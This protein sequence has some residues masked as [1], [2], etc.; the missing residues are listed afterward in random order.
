MKKAMLVVGVLI[1]LFLFV[2][3]QAQNA[4]G[5]TVY[6]DGAALQFD[7]NPV[8]ENGRTLVPFRAIFEALGCGVR[9][10][11]TEGR[12]TVSAHRGEDNLMLTIGENKMYF[13]E[14]EIAL[15]APAKIVDNRTLVPL[16]AVSEAFSTAVLWEE[17]TKTVSLF[18][19]QGEHKI[20]PAIINKEIKNADGVVIMNI[21]CSYPVIANNEGSAFIDKINAEYKTEAE[22]FVAAA[23][24]SKADAE[25]Y[26]ALRDLSEA[27]PYE[28]MQTFAVNTDKNGYLSITN[29][30]YTYYGGAHGLMVQRSRTFDL[31]NNKELALTDILSGDVNEKVYSVFSE[32]FEWA[33]GPGFDENWSNLLKSELGNVR[34]YITED[35]LVL[36]FD[37]Y[38]VASYA[39]GTPRVELPFRENDFLLEF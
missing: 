10:A 39:F 1:G 32:Y 16:R 7:V 17:D 28:N 36:Y 31:K 33:A 19:K 13:G 5:I 23:E 15:D 20:S 9:Y 8:I 4:D 26:Y 24:E 35:S 25:V 30:T 3:V 34:F 11:N 38:A 21:S 22:N 6:L 12:Q 27:V 29:H 37:V 18:S 2:P 14:K